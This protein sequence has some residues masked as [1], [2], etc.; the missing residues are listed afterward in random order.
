MSRV[1]NF[2]PGPATLP[3][4]ALE[5][6][7]Q[8]L[9]EYQGTGMSILET[10]HRSKEYEAINSEAEARIKRLLGLDD[11]YR[12][13]FLQGGASLQFAMLPYNFLREE[14]TADY[15]LTGSW[16]E[17][18][19]NEAGNFGTIYPIHVA[20]TT[21]GVN[22]CRIPTPDEI[23]LSDEPAY[24]HITSNNTI[25]GTQWHEFPNVGEAPLVADMSSDIL[26]RPFDATKLSL[27]YAGAQKNIGP[28]GV[29][30]VVLRESWLEKANTSIP[31]FLSYATHV[32]SN[33]LYN[34]PPVFSVYLL[35]LILEEMEQS[36]GLEA[37]G[38]RNEEKARHIYQAI[39]DNIEFYLP[40]ATPESRSLINIT[41]RLTSD[42]LTKQFI[43]EAAHE[44]MVGLKGHRSVGGIRVS[45]YNAM[46][47]EG[48]EALASFMHQFASR[49]G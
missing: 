25:Y 26:S 23:E 27:F 45:L 20:A 29:T 43:N 5:R 28:A 32:K 37:M 49:N 36:G 4:A 13:L 19:Y 44:G 2:N 40:H 10:S 46:S 17:K 14:T 33:S 41:F 30:V 15:I 18:A 42:D 24:V 39:D 1:Y 3:V 31:I 11:A 34:T 38:K 12:V 35:N 21:R 22:Y 8:E 6:A 16:S 7:Q 9:L 48:S 47:V